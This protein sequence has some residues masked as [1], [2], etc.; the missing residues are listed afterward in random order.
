MPNLVDISTISH[1][2]LTVDQVCAVNRTARSSGA[3]GGKAQTPQVLARQESQNKN[4][5]I[6]DFGSGP[7]A[8]QTIF[9]RSQGYTNVESY[10][11]GCNKM[12]WIHSDILGK[13]YDIVF[14]SNVLN[15][16]P[17]CTSGYML[18]NELAGHVQPRGTLYVNFPKSPRKNNLT[19]KNIEFFLREY[20]SSV[21]LL[22]NKVFVANGKRSLYSAE[23]QND[24][25]E[26]FAE[27]D[28]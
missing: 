7:Q 12:D 14:A 2:T 19:E 26:C 4:A 28:S 27:L 1:H 8:L 11:I 16:Q 10:E 15:V 23:E 25:A 6:L 20:F 3:V 22:A 17:D 13:T 9:L 5:S 21:I 18:I 24:F